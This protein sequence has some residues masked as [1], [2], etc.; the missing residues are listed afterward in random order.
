MKKLVLTTLFMMS[1]LVTFA[2]HIPG[3]VLSMPNEDIFSFEIKP[4]ITSEFIK[5]ETNIPAQSLHI[6]VI[7]KAGFIRIEKKLH[8]ERELDV[9]SLRKGYYLIKIYTENSMA[10]K[11]FYKGQDAVNNK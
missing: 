10:I 1:I 6:K 11:R 3:N 5:I 7:D 8:L 4:S 9:S 2:N